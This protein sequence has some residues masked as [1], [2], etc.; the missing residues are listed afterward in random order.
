M[1]SANIPE[2]KERTSLLVGADSVEILNRA[3]ILIVGLGGVGGW[4]A[5]VLARAGVGEMTLVDADVVAPSNIN[6]QLV[7][8]H[9]TIG[10]PKC[11]V[12]AERLQEINPEIKLHVLRLFVKDEATDE[13]LD[14]A[15]YDVVLDAIDSLS[16]KVYLIA[17]SIRKGL[18][19]ISS[20]G[21]GAKWDPSAIQ[22]ADISRSHN[23]TLA[24]SVRKRLRLLGIHKG[25][26]VVYSTELPHSEAVISVSG[27]CCKR[28]TAG[29]LSYMPAAFGMR[30]A[31]EA[32]RI[33]L[34][35]KLI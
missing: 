31:A 16:P 30:M 10:Q 9:K 6:R 29:T 3:H 4:A 7:A 15:K 23:C 24:R 20:M 26:S 1:S 12:L 34:D 17:L 2:W 11:D 21:A 5:E 18:R 25:F 28:S 33:L 35:R 22:V 8:T 13:L 19:L 14:R 32:I 27:E